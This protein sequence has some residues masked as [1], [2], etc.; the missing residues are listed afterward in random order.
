MKDTAFGRHAK[1]CHAGNMT[2][3]QFFEQAHPVLVRMGATLMRR[4]RTPPAVSL[5]DV[6]QELMVGCCWAFKRYDP[7]R[8]GAAPIGRFV[9]YNACDKAKKWIHRQRGAL[10]HGKTDNSPPRYAVLL[11][12]VA[13]RRSRRGQG[14]TAAGRAA[15]V[16]WAIEGL[17]TEP[18]QHERLEQQEYWRT[19]F[20]KAPTSRLRWGLLALG[21]TQGDPGRA[22]ARIYADPDLRLRLHLSSERDA[23][24]VIREVV[25]YLGTPE[26][27][28][29][30]GEVIEATT[31]D[32]EARIAT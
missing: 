32:G 9:M 24:G 1:A 25:R 6:V 26:F 20:S 16:E 30:A 22:T 13:E 23:R 17:R 3:R 15:D 14:G 29:M 7:K 11:Q 21:A 19:L 10:L 12:D 27:A 5:E 28:G 8:A 4:W 2:L 31:D 18:E